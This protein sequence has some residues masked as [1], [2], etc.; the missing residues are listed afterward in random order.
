VLIFD[1]LGESGELQLIVELIERRANLLLVEDEIILECARKIGPQENRYRVSLP[2]HPYVLPPPQTD[3]LNP[4]E[5]SP[6]VINRLLMQTPNEKA[7]LALVKHVYGFSPLLAKEAV[8]RAYQRVNLTAAEAN[9]YSLDAALASFLPALLRHEWQ[10]GVAVDEAGLAQG[11]AVYPLT[12][13]GVWQPAATVSEA[14]NTYYGRLEGSAAYEAAREPIRQ[15]LENAREKVARKLASLH[16][17]LVDDSEF[18]RL[19]KSGELLLAYQYTIK[20]GQTLLEAQYEVD[21]EPLQIELDPAL[22]PLENA[23]SYFARYD[24]AKRGRRQLPQHIEETQHELEFLDQLETDLML[25]E[26][27]QDIGEVQETLMKKGY[28]QGKRTEHPKGGRS[29]PL[30]FT[31]PDGFVIWV[32]R[33][34]RQNE[35]VTFRKA[36][37][38]DLWLHARE[39]PG[40][41]VVI[42]T[43]GRKVPQAVIEQAAALAAYYSKQREETKVKVMLAERRHVRKLKRGHTGQVLVRQE[44]RSIMVKPARPD[45]SP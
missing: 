24:K 45:E 37:S 41:H 22:T 19:R 26:N 21:G 40:A 43:N 27:W 20:P 28:W 11:V 9:P 35:D 16:R 14:L 17:S 6:R 5:L 18:E 8:F 44:L 13:L 32:G 29:G 2:Q 3:K 12:H 31:T 1:M 4:D 30:R 10:A 42:K 23:Q 39:A 25:A 34:A 7:W 36:D 33:N 38:G 15:Q